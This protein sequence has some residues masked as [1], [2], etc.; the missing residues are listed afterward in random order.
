MRRFIAGAT[1]TGLSVASSKV[2]AASTPG[3]FSIDVQLTADGARKMRAATA[4][5]IGRPV[6]ILLDGDVV[7]A[8]TVRSAIGGAAMITGDYTRAQAERIVSGM[9]VTP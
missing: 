9:S 7:M 5:H 4:A 8:P 2:V 3:Q 6:A 1:T